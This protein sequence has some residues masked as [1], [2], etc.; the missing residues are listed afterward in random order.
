MVILWHWVSGRKLLMI[1]AMFFI[2][3][4]EYQW[5]D[6]LSIEVFL[7]IVNLLRPLRN[8]YSILW[9]L[10]LGISLWSSSSLR[11]WVERFVRRGSG[12][13]YM[14]FHASLVNRSTCNC[15]SDRT[16]FCIIIVVISLILI[17]I[18]TIYCKGNLLQLI[19][20][21][22]HYWNHYWLKWRTVLV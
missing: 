20:S 4:V 18:K 12:R 17:G 8:W 21:T 22:N 10:F 16:L 11:K 1:S 15:N 19:I 9:N 3:N 7:S 6:T 2:I 14:N 13:E 5:R